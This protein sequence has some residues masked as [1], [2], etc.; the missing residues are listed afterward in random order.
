MTHRIP[1]LRQQEIL[2][3]ICISAS[4]G[5]ICVGWQ[6]PHHAATNTG[7]ALANAAKFAAKSKSLGN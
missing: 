3:P 6:A 1:S 2:F 5:R 7:Q 4:P